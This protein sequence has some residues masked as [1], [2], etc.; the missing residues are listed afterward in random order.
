MEQLKEY[1]RLNNLTY[2]EL[3]QHEKNRMDAFFSRLK[4]SGVDKLVL[5]FDPK[6]NYITIKDMGNGEAEYISSMRSMDLDNQIKVL[7]FNP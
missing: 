7:F 6:I 4:D 5:Q 3:N 1:F 2:E